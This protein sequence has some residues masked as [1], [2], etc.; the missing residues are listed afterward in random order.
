[1]SIRTNR[2]VPSG[3]S[4]GAERMT[5]VQR[6]RVVLV[7]E[8]GGESVKLTKPV[9]TSTDAAAL[10]RPAFEG[11]DREQFVVM[12]LDTKHRPIGL[13][14]VALGSLN[15]AVVHPREVFKPAVVAS[16]ASLILGHNHPSGIAEPSAEDIEIT[17]RLRE[18][19]EIIGIR[20][21][22]HVIL[23]DAEYFSF[24]DSGRL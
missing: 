21:L 6:Y 15:A 1:M 23:G 5:K 16:A 9:R 10:L 19:G 12:M 7:R 22:D 2:D 4:L 18:V 24:S 17:H 3:S 8:H 11:L 13:N 20:V 14:V